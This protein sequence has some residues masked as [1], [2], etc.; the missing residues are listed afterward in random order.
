MKYPIKEVLQGLRYHLCN[1][2]KFCSGNPSKVFEI[3]MAHYEDMSIL[4][5]MKSFTILLIDGHHQKCR[6]KMYF[7]DPTAPPI[8]HSSMIL[9]GADG[10]VSGKVIFFRHL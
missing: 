6:V 9:G 3:D 8:F 2:G 7:T 5:T 10:S 1:R 4:M